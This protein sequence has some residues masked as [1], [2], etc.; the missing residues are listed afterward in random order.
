MALYAASTLYHAL[1]QG[2]GKRVS[3]TLEHCVIFVLI[4]GTYTP[5]TLIAIRGAWGWTL[6]GH[7]WSLAGVG[8]LLKTVTTTKYH[9]WHLFVLAGTTCHFIAVWFYVV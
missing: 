3:R 8:M 4:A 9:C 6:F 1:G 2:R 7:V 5:V